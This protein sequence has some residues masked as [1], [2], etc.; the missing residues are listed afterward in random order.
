VK[1]RQDAVETETRSFLRFVQLM[2]TVGEGDET[3]LS[4]LLL[5]DLTG[6]S[7]FVAI[8]EMPVKQTQELVTAWEN[9]DIDFQKH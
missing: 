2:S 5:Y 7:H 8:T 3:N 6:P 4:G 9:S 1:Q